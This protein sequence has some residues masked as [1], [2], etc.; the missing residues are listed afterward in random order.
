MEKYIDFNNLRPEEFEELCFQLILKNDFIRITW[1]R[2]D[3]DNGRDIEAYYKV[4]NNIIGE[5]YEKFFF[6]CKKYEKGVPPSE[7]NSKIAWADAERPKHLVIFVSSYLTNNAREWIEKI[8]R[9]KYYSIHVIEE[10]E[11]INLLLKH[12]DLIS[13]YF[14][15]DKNKKL[16][17]ET[18]EKWL[19]YN[20]IPDFYTYYYLLENL[21]KS[22]LTTKEVVF[23]YILYFT[24][25]SKLEEVDNKEYHG[26]DISS[27]ILELNEI[28]VRNY[29]SMDF[30]L[31]NRTRIE[32]LS[33]EGLL[34][35]DEEMISEYNYDFIA[36]QLILHSGMRDSENSTFKMANY[37]F[38]RI[39]DTEFIEILLQQNS[40]LEYK[41]HYGNSY[42]FNTYEKAVNLLDYSKSVISKILGLSIP[43]K[44][45]K[46]NI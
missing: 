8:K 9:D 3:T 5:Q 32:T 21:D 18:I 29:N 40:S 12:D 6:E 31:K 25:Y 2:G 33:G 46:I 45:L 30:I 37:M 34:C 11:I 15:E 38:R 7:L 41:I 35:M 27:D 14:I 26:I 22:S 36:T 43:M 23:L 17:T 28:L 13:K 1:R 16:L 24:H 4:H 19:I 10:K 39:S 44:K 20:L 42:T